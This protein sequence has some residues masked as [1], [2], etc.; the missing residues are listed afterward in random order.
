MVRQT[1]I[2]NNGSIDALPAFA[3]KAVP[4]R[5]PVIEGEQVMHVAII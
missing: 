1:V 2:W 5:D 4:F 3:Q